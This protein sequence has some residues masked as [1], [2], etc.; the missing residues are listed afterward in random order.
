MWQAMYDRWD[1]SCYRDADYC[2]AGAEVAVPQ[3]TEY[4][5]IDPPYGL[6]QHALLA[7]Y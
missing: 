1:S 2:K 5:R 4:V 3:T 7:L 6:I